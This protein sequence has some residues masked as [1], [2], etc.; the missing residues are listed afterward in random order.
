MSRTEVVSRNAVVGEGRYWG[1]GRGEV[2]GELGQL[3]AVA[4]VVQ[5]Y[6]DVAVDD[7]VVENVVAGEDVVGEDVETAEAVVGQHRTAGPKSFSD[8]PR[9]HGRAVVLISD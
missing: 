4:D 1:R 6:D 5:E 9:R 7:D 2:G 8:W 3:A